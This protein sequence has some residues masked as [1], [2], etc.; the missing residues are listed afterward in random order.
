MAKLRLSTMVLPL[1]SK[2]AMKRYFEDLAIHVA[3]QGGQ[4]CAATAGG[5]DCP[6]Q[7]LSA[8]RQSSPAVQRRNGYQRGTLAA[9]QD[10]RRNGNP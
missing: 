1:L 10:P 7:W 5:N 8:L 2:L 3:D 6:A 9:N 4:P